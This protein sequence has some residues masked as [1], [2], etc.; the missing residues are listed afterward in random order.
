MNIGFLITA[1]LKSSRLKLK[2]LMPL[3]GVTVVEHVINRA[4]KIEGCSDIVLC[5]SRHN[6]DLPLMRISKNN[7]IYYYAG[8]SED[9]LQ[10][11]LDAAEI[12]NMDYIIGITADNPLFSIY[13]ANLISDAVRLD[14]SLDFIYTS[15]LPV[16]VNIYAIKTKALKTVCKIK[17]EI[18]TEIWGYLVN[19]PEIF[20]I[21]EINVDNYFQ[22]EGYRMTLDEFDDYSFF[23]SLYGGFPEG[24]VVDVLDAYKFL[25][26][27][28]DIVDINKHVIQRDLDLSAQKRISDFYDK[29][30]K[31]IL[32]I[33]EK[34]YLE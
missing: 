10:R 25:D 4:K 15:G 11:M 13:H 26:S 14:S 29:N 17:E 9:V 8:S 3:N 18:D 21:K 32:G 6:Q 1:R 34:I 24:T 7:N 2:L 5:T 19:R 12:F 28:A 30:K 27:N 16:G 33:K 20:N 22:R 23:N 31:I